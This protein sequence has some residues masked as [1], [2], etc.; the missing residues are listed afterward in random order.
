MTVRVERLDERVTRVVLDRP[1][2]RNALDAQQWELLTA[3]F[4]ELA[5]DP[6]GCLVLTGAGE[7]FAAGGDLQQFRAELAVEGG[8][9]AFHQ[10]IRACLDAVRDFPAPTVAR[11]N[12]PAMGGG[13]ELAISCDVCVAVPEA[14]F[15]M[16]A[17]SFGIVMAIA[18]VNHL[19]TAVGASAARYLT[20]TGSTIDGTEA[21][22]IGLVHELAERD[23]LDRVVERLAARLATVDRDAA[24]WFREACDVPG[25]TAAGRGRNA[26][27]LDALRAREL[28]LLSDPALLG[29]VDRF[30]ERRR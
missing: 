22:R 12:G 11:V 15:A 13:F 26:S 6:P 25:A 5:E 21:H 7:T 17:V 2:R 29:R 20:M 24:L 8:P 4:H 16:P 3:T 18:D 30:L 27:E 14:L 1:A 23:E 9:E 19:V 10:R 28:K